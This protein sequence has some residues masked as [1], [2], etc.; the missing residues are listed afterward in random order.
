MHQIVEDN[1]LGFND[2]KA[3]FEIEIQQIALLFTKLLFDYM[4]IEPLNITI[5]IF[6]DI[7][8]KDAILQLIDEKFYA[9]KKESHHFL[10]FVIFVPSDHQHIDLYLDEIGVIAKAIVDFMNDLFDES[11][12]EE[13]FFVIGRSNG[14]ITDGNEFGADLVNDKVFIDA[15]FAVLDF[16]TIQ[17]FIIFF[18]ALVLNFNLR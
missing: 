9:I 4:Q 10:L 12:D 18:F 15:L 1:N 5:I 7:L 14:L 8:T 6:F 17:F 16:D 13:G 3:F 2:I 11:D